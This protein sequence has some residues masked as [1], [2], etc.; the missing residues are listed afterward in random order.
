MQQANVNTA[1]ARDQ[2]KPQ[3]DLNLN[4][5]ENGFAGKLTPLSQNPLTPLFLGQ[6]TAINELIERVNALTPDAAAART[7]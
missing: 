4:V 7:A 5:S 1:Y 3:I 2:T 6:T